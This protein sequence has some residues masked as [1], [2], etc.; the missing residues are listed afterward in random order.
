MGSRIRLNDKF[1]DGAGGGLPQRAPVC[2]KVYAARYVRALGLRT[3]IDF[4]PKRAGDESIGVDRLAAAALAPLRP[5][6]YLLH[7]IGQWLT[8]RLDSADSVRR[9]LRAMRDWIAATDFRRLDWQAERTTPAILLA[10]RE[11]LRAH[12]QPRTVNTAMNV[13]RSWFAWL[14]EYGLV[15][16]SP[17]RRDHLVPVDRARLYHPNR[18]GHVRRSLAADQLQ[19]LVAWVFSEPRLPKVAVALLLMAC[20]GL[21][22]GEVVGADHDWLYQDGA[23]RC[24]TVRGK[25]KRSRSIILEPVVVQA[26]DRYLAM[27]EAPGRPPTRGPLLRG[28]GGRRLHRDTISRW[29]A[30]FGRT[31]DRP[32]LTTHELRRTYAT[33]VRDRGAPIEYTQRH[34]G[35]SSPALTQEFYDVGDR[36][37]RFT[38]GIAPVTAPESA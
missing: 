35:H 4:G 27:H 16:R 18:I 19:A 13:L 23:D 34:L 14:H 15:E 11:H 20:A 38:T 22:R 3:A 31:I 21:R 30:A 2:S 8:A 33:I 1:T 17:W 37:S 10:Y 6:R 5:E 29:V 24:M 7:A 26:I 9:Y 28:R 12:H 36:R 25:G 32:D